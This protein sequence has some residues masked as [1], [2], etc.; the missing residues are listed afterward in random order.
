MEEVIFNI[1][2]SIRNWKKKLR[3]NRTLEDGYI[4]ELEQHLRD[5]IERN[6]NT[7]MSEEEAFKN[8]VRN[9]GEV[10]AI[11]DEYFKT[12]TTN[13]V[14]GRPSWQAPSWMPLLFWSYFKTSL[15]YFRK[16]K[17]YTFINVFGL[18]L[19]IT[20]STF[21]A[22]YVFD[23]L[24][25]DNF[26][27]NPDSIYRVTYQLKTP[28]AE[29]HHARTA[30][31]YGP[32]LKNDFPEIKYF[33]RVHIGSEIIKY[34][35]QSYQTNKFYYTDKD[36]FNIFGFNLIEGDPNTVLSS[37]FSITMSE[38]EAHKIF[39]NENPVGKTI[40][41]DDTLTYTVTGIF[42]DVPSNSHFKPNYL[43]A[44]S[45]P[46][47]PWMNMWGNNTYYSYVKL[48]SAES[49]PSLNAGIPQFIDKYLSTRLDDGEKLDIVFQPV[50]DIHLYS[51]IRDELE[52]GGNITYVIIL[53]AAALFILLIASINFLNLTL[54]RST[55][56]TK[57]I[58]MRKVVGAEKRNLIYQFVG[59]SIMLTFG[60]AVISAIII[61][62][63]L[64]YFNE[65]TGKTIALN[66]ESLSSL[67]PSALL[68]VLVLG[69]M[70]G[71]YPALV[72]SS[73]KVAKIFANKSSSPS[74]YSQFFRRA[75]IT[76]QFVISVSLI[77]GTIIIS[78]Q[79]KF[80]QN[81]ELGFNKDQILVV[82]FSSYYNDVLSNYDA[83]RNQLLSNPGI[84]SVTMS[85]DIPGDMNTSLS[86]YA[87]GMP[88]NTSDAITAMIVEPDFLKTYDMVI[89]A[90]R[91]FSREIQT[92]YDEAMIINE[93]AAKSIGWTPE[94]AIGKR[95]DMMKGGK[96]I[97]VVKDFHFYSLH[98]SI[99]PVAIT[100]WPDWFGLIS[101]KMNAKNLTQ[102]IA[103]IEQTFDGMFPGKPFNYS[104]FDENFNKQ[105]EADQKFQQIFFAFSLLTIG[106]A[107]LG[108][109][110]L[111]S[112]SAERKT[113]EIGIRKVL[114]AGE[115]SLVYLLV[116]EFALLVVIAN[117]VALPVSYYVVSSWLENFAYRISI[118]WQAF[119]LAGVLSLL[120]SLLSVGFHAY[121]ATKKNP[122]ETLRAE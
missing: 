21:I 33:T 54:A 92:D 46:N 108:I 55:R 88:V 39:G 114:G 71:L 112:F 99:E 67:I 58:A 49:F 73:Q 91:D 68:L 69:V 36:A 105:Y 101:I 30:P 63:T 16:E 85:G 100:Y 38:T 93:S 98:K 60:A 96:I 51:N 115:A 120:I 66:R 102:T 97:G 110:G 104:F 84:A 26:H 47:V 41:L 79:L 106:I 87:E 116:K 13:R 57:E 1:E 23:E 9:V 25:Y 42:K 118:G 10:E 62:I 72:V 65:F 43:A 5:E 31:L 11:D 45:N 103:G 18:V 109:F 113:K 14:S 15:R 12:S 86:Y 20:A 95:F 17:L 70:S 111:I 80:I 74:G 75:L 52:P 64:P 121:N 59:E 122:V 56:R 35:G 77:T 27:D 4:E 29:F 37:P 28:T 19:G 82:P 3:K 40:F 89:V 48:N 32:T 76:I 53:S 117:I 119:A 6:V 81:K 8:A 50:T 2:N 61:G 107:C 22:M 44:Y 24:S 7:G 78:S 90:G 94:E 83:L 34:S